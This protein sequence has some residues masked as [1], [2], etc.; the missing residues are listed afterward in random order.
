MLWHGYKFMICIYHSCLPINQ[1]MEISVCFQQLALMN[2]AAINIVYRF[3]KA[4]F[5]FFWVTV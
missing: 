1:L 5:H 4:R 3:L 2:K